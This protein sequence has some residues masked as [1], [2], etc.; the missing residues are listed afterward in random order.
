M[1]LYNFKCQPQDLTKEM[2][3]VL[4]CYC[5]LTNCHKRR[6]FKQ[7]TFVSEL[8]SVDVAWLGPLLWGLTGLQSRCWRGPR[9]QQRLK[10]RK[11]VSW[12]P[13]GW[14]QNSSPFNSK[15]EALP[16]AGHCPGPAFSSLGLPQLL[17]MWTCQCQQLASSRPKR[18]RLFPVFKDRVFYNETQSEEWHLPCEAN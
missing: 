3:F 14:W 8:P 4:V 17:V 7:H 10:W 12:D 16:I 13:S 5:C 18:K 11:T 6:G 15:T 2:A 9:C 1:I